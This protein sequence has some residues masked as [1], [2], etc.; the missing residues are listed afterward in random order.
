MADFASASVRIFCGVPSFVGK[1]LSA[2]RSFTCSCECPPETKKQKRSNQV[3]VM[4]VF[5]GAFARSWMHVLVRI[6][7]I[8][9]SLRAPQ[10]DHRRTCIILT[11]C[12]SYVMHDPLRMATHVRMA[13]RPW[14]VGLFRTKIAALRRRYQQ[15]LF[16]LEKGVTRTYSY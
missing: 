3:S 11:Q 10:S 12:T 6:L 8:P 13:P 5:T 1:S 16:N 7:E 15:Y 9:F 2:I 4:C 14:L